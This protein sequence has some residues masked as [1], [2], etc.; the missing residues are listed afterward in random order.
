MPDVSL[1]RVAALEHHIVA[2]LAADDN[3]FV[4]LPSYF[5]LVS[6]LRPEAVGPAFRD[7]V[8][9]SEAVQPDGGGPFRRNRAAQEIEE[10]AAEL[11]YR[12][13]EDREGDIQPV[14]GGYVGRYPG[15]HVYSAARGKAVE[16]HGAIRDKYNVLGGPHGRL[17][18]PVTDEL[19][20]PDGAGRFNHFAGGSI[21]WSPRTGP[22][23]VWGKVRD[24]WAATGWE[25][26]PFGYP[27]MDQHQTPRLRPDTPVIE[28]C[29]FENGVIAADAAEARDCL[30]AEVS[31][32]ELGRMFGARL[33][34]GFLASPDNVGMRPS[35]GLTGVTD[36]K[37]D[38][39]ASVPRAV[40]FQY[41][42][43]RDNGLLPDTDFAIDIGVR[44]ELVWQ[45]T[46][47]E[48]TRKSLVAVLE[49]LR[50]RH[51]GVDDNII[52]GLPAAVISAVRRAV[53]GA[54]H[55]AV[56][57]DPEHPEVPRGALFVAELETGANAETGAID[58]LDVLVASNGA[59]QVIVNPLETRGGPP[60]LIR[61]QLVQTAVNLVVD[62]ALGR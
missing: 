18:L 20:T 26:G 7:L 13:E 4:E 38:F 60:P 2:T 62:R 31:Y 21:Y 56:W 10:R 32:E 42:G 55:P 54:F 40:G 57:P 45:P 46:F 12:P 48:A 30:V 15:H 36:W 23:A 33:T 14:P 35:L 16:V 50:V 9:P 5:D 41:R 29:R 49:F 58:V 22:M 51:V 52:P 1:S 61:Q 37:Y 6:A 53:A 43:F 17:G 59:L 28:W 25:R 47:T 8:R 19:G 3:A 39:W 27:T 34:A 24:R 44:L 11:G